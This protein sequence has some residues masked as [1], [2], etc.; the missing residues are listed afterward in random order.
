MRK[1]VLMPFI[2]QS[3]KIP[4]HE[5]PKDMRKG[6]LLLMTAL[7][8]QAFPAC[9]QKAPEKIVLRDGSVVY[10]YRTLDVPERFRSD[11]CDKYVFQKTDFSPLDDA[12]YT[13]KDGEEFLSSRHCL[14]LSAGKTTLKDRRSVQFFLQD[15]F[16]SEGH[17]MYFCNKGKCDP[18]PDGPYALSNG[19]NFRIS[20]G[21]LESGG[22][23]ENGEIGYED[24]H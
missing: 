11:R 9:A 7:L 6:T 12:L 2:N 22:F 1:K 4:P 10:A 15:S 5:R 20:G 16:N 8:V 17:A 24:R 19:Q 13:T 3:K 21:A 23:F 14:L 18:A